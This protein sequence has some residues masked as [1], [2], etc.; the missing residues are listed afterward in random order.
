[1]KLIVLILLTSREKN[2]EYS[3]H[4]F[5]HF[6][7]RLKKKDETLYFEIF[8]TIDTSKLNTS[9]NYFVKKGFWLKSFIQFT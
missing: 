4:A 5:K 2:K 7:I 1:M 3:L 8:P 9:A 6:I